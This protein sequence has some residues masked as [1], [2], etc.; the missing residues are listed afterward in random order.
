MIKTNSTIKK[1]GIFIGLFVIIWLIVNLLP[2]ATITL[3][4][5]Q[6]VHCSLNYYLSCFNSHYQESDWGWYPRFLTTDFGLYLSMFIIP[7]SLTIIIYY[8]INKNKL[9]VNKK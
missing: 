6:K 1:I 3:N 7:F 4:N 8:F 5:N 9:K 2:I